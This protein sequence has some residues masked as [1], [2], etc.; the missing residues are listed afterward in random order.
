MTWPIVSLTAQPT[1]DPCSTATASIGQIAS[2]S[3]GDPIRALAPGGSL[4]HWYNWSFPLWR[5]ADQ[6]GT[7]AVCGDHPARVL[8][9]AAGCRWAAQ[10]VTGAARL[11]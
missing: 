11:S 1:H 9:A 8:I 4:I 2:T 6:P 7:N 10:A 3:C 5:L